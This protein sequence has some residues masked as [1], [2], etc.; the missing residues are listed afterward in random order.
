MRGKELLRMVA[1]Q[2]FGEASVSPIEI[3]QRRSVRTSVCLRPGVAKLQ[4]PKRQALKITAGDAKTQGMHDW[5]VTDESFR[6][7]I[8][9]WLSSLWCKS[10]FVGKNV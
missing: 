5:M 6:F 9:P 8:Y 7:R 10:G 2:A 1:P 4:V 3:H